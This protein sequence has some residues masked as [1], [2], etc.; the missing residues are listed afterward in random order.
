[1]SLRGRVGKVKE[2]GEYNG[3]KQYG[4]FKKGARKYYNPLSDVELIF[5]IAV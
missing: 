5:E 3:K 2:V 1:M 4:F